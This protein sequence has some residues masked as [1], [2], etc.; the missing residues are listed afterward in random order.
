[1]L[2]D[3]SMNTSRYFEKASWNKIYFLT[4][5]WSFTIPIDV[6]MPNI[7]I[8]P[9]QLKTATVALFDRHG[10]SALMY[11]S[12]FLS[13]GLSCDLI[14]SGLLRSSTGSPFFAGTPSSSY[15]WFLKKKIVELLLMLMLMHS[16]WFLF[17]FNVLATDRWRHLLRSSQK[18][19]TYSFENQPSGFWSYRFSFFT[20]VIGR[21]QRI[22]QSDEYTA[23]M[24]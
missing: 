19:E 8:K 17:V 20:F 11:W 5:N 7:I 23:K 16:I 13:G 15:C 1:M 3:Y 22:S 10:N 21:Y 2:H 9:A 6:L 24:W 12:I 18:I 14:L 4:S